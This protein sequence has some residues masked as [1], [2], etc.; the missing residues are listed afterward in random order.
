MTMNKSGN[1]STLYFR[2]YFNLVMSAFEVDVHLAKDYIFNHIFKGDET[3]RGTLSY[4]RFL[5]AYQEIKD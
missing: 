1:L 2:S 3:Y 5:C 4:E